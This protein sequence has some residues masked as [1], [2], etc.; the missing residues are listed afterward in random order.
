MCNEMKLS[1]GLWY[2]VF[3]S[4]FYAFLADIRILFLPLYILVDLLLQY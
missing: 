2:T 4:L 3:C 1:L